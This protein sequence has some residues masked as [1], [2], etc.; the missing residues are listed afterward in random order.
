L[1]NWALPE[2]FQRIRQLLEARMGNR[3]KREF[4]QILRLME[5]GSGRKPG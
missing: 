4:I 5:V 1:R 3:G 2:G